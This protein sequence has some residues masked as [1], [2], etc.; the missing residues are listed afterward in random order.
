L[1]TRELIDQAI[2]E[3]G[4]YYLPYQILATKEQFHAA[5]PRATEFIKLK[6]RVDP[7]N[8]FRNRLLDAYYEPGD[9]FRVQMPSY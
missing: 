1:R 2:S 3:G 5:Y 8:K 6:G 7:H 9:G 4:A